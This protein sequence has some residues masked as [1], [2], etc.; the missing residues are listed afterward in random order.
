[1]HYENSVERKTISYVGIMLFASDIVEINGFLLIYLRT[2]KQIK[3]FRLYGHHVTH[4]SQV[5]FYTIY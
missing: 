4:I 5:F 1:M 3:P 2:T